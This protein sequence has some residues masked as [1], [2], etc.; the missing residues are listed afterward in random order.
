MDKPALRCQPVDLRVLLKWFAG[1]TFNMVTNLGSDLGFA[2]LNLELWEVT[3]GNSALLAAT[4]TTVVGN[5]EYLRLDLSGDR[6]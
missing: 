6:N 3:D 2:D 1:R 5:S 4:A